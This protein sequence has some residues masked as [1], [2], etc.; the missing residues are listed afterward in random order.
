ML[1]MPIRIPGSLWRAAIAGGAAVAVSV[2]LLAFARLPWRLA[3]LT[4][5]EAGALSLLAMAW[6]TIAGSS[7]EATRQRASRDDPGRTF[8]YAL[9][10]LGS[11]VNLLSATF[12]VRRARLLAGP[13]AD[14]LVALCLANVL[15]CWALTHT[16]FALRYAHLYYRDDD[17]GVGGVE[18]PGGAQPSDFD[19]AYLAFTIGMTFQVS[20]TTV[21]S[22]QIRRAVLL[23][24]TLSFVYNTAV[25]AFVLNLVFGLAG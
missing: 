7:A 23:H 8:L 19:F 16:A 24:A 4:G 9:V 12:L 21:S 17:E 15:L 11:G 25:L 3:A 5:W 22:P 13:Q 2:G 1:A 6:L 10:L 14:L 20:D 18:F